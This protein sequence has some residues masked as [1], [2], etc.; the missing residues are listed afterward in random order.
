MARKTTVVWASFPSREAAEQI[1]DRLIANGFARNSIELFRQG[2][3]TGCDVAVHTSEPNV[4]RVERLLNASA[5]VYAMRTMSSGALKTVT[6]NP[7]VI[8]AS[9]ALAGVV[10]YS[11]LPRN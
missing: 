5:A 2:D 4:R 6:S 7:L 3:G 9:L 1:K 10:L 11:L 8:A